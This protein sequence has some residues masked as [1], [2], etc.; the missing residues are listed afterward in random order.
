MPDAMIQQSS[1]PFY[2]TVMTDSIEKGEK[3]EKD[4]YIHAYSVFSDYRSNRVLALAVQLHHQRSRIY[5]V[6]KVT[7]KRI[8][9]LRIPHS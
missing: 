5:T 6:Y 9:R 3:V 8:Q 1:I 7:Y 4:K 2:R